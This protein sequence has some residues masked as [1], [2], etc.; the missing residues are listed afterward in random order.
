MIHKQ[1]RIYDHK[2][3]IRHRSK[4]CD[5]Q[6]DDWT[7]RRKDE[8]LDGRTNGRLDERIYRLAD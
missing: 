2:L 3:L 7:D 8:R 4:M 5:G 1:G 6:T